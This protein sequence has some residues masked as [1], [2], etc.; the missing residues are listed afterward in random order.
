MVMKPR[1]VIVRWLNPV[2]SNDYYISE[3]RIRSKNLLGISPFIFYP[4]IFYGILRM[5]R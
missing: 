5:Y 1:V 2:S 4:E 3:E